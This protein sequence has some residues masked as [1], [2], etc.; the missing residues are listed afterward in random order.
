MNQKKCQLE[1]W[2]FDIPKVDGDISFFD[3]FVFNSVH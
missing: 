1:V 3:G 2:N